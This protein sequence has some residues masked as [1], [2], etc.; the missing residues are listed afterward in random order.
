M[1]LSLSTLL[2]SCNQQEIHIFGS[3][4]S[5]LLGI[6]HLSKD[7]V[8]IGIGDAPIRLRKHLHTDYW[9]SANDDFP[10]PFVQQH[11]Q[12]INTLTRKL[13]VFSDSVLY[14]RKW[15]IRDTLDEYLTCD[16]AT[17]DQRHFHSSPCLTNS[18]CCRLL[19][20]RRVPELTI[21]ELTA[22]CFSASTIYSTGHT[23]AIHAFAFALL[24][25]PKS[26]YIHG[27]DLN[28]SRSQYN[29]HPS[30]LAD[31][32]TIPTVLQWD[33]KLQSGFKS[34]DVLRALILASL[35]QFARIKPFK[36]PTS[37]LCTQFFSDQA[38]QANTED[39]EYLASLAVKS[40]ISVYTSNRQSLLAQIP[41]IRAMTNY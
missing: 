35:P 2:G 30:R 31:S 34:I 6:P 18:N 27:V 38:L 13:F 11:A 37:Y 9:V 36:S 16:W 5:A 24:M 25:R 8:T 33:Y 40:D 26:I 15:M 32:V 14:S 28:S 4:P 3:A 22:R 12:Y 20:T 7:S 23:V 19:S 21:Q 10:V 41:G 29:Y 1:R 17:F 39:L